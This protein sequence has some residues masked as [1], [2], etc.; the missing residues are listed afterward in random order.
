M[1]VR[2]FNW[3]ATRRCLLVY[4]GSRVSHFTGNKWFWPPLIKVVVL[5]FANSSLNYQYR[6]LKVHQE[7]A[8][9]INKIYWSGSSQFVGKYNFNLKLGM[10]SFWEY[11]PPFKEGL[12]FRFG[13]LSPESLILADQ[14][15]LEVREKYNAMGSADSR[16]ETF[17]RIETKSIFHE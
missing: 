10:S 8:K 15:F 11:L 5:Y 17:F 1:P 2:V 7:C 9:R 3:E 16:K 13:P 4:T 6:W 14:T 12:L